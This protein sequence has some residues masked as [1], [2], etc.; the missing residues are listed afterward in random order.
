MRT[1]CPGSGF[2]LSCGPLCTRA[3][4]IRAVLLCCMGWATF[5]WF[6]APGA[7]LPRRQLLWQNLSYWATYAVMLLLI[8]FV[9]GLLPPNRYAEYASVGAACLGTFALTRRW[10]RSGRQC[11]AD[12]GLRAESGTGLRFAWGLLA[13]F[14]LLALLLAVPLLLHGGRFVPV[15]HPDRS[16]ALWASGALFLGAWHQEIAFR[17]YPVRTLTPAL[18][19]WPSQL[20]IAAA[21]GLYHLVAGQGLVAALVGTGT[22]SLFYGFSALATGGIA[23]PT[24]VHTALNTGQSLIGGPAALWQLL[25]PPAA[26]APWQGQVQSS[27]EWVRYALVLLCVGAL[28][29]WIRRK[30][31]R[32]DTVSATC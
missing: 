15:A 18:G 5:S 3:G 27:A 24:G 29:G 13:G 22:W 12:I 9:H 31:T 28:A 2:S 32:L 7:H 8:G 4:S 30:R 1:A 26:P 17:A 16:R 19:V 6:G 10:L 14:F 25:P 23:F 21:F 20:L 11:L